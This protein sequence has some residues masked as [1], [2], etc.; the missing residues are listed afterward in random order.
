MKQHMK[1]HM[2]HHTV[3]QHMKQHMKLHMKLHMKQ[4]MKQH[5]RLH[6]KLHLNAISTKQRIKSMEQHINHNPVES[7]CLLGGQ[8]LY[9]G[10]R[11]WGARSFAEAA[12]C[13]LRLSPR[14]FMDCSWTVRY[15]HGRER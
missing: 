8:G 12:T 9:I 7:A 3:K 15:C 1:H 4:H 2:K 11:R 5:M 10:A 13:H 6:M 14:F